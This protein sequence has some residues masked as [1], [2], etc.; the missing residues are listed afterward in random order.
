M[1]QNIDVTVDG[2]LNRFDPLNM[3]S[4][5]EI[6]GELVKRWVPKDRLINRVEVNGENL[7]EQNQERL[8]A[9]RAADIQRIDIQTEPF[10]EAVGGALER[11][12]SYL[13]RVCEGLRLCVDRFRAGQEIEAHK[14]MANS[15]EGL[16]WF[17]GFTTN[18]RV[19]LKLDYDS[20]FFQG[21]SL[22]AKQERLFEYIRELE[23]AQKNMDVVYMA[24]LLEFEIE[25]ILKNWIEILPAFRGRLEAA[26]KS[27]G[28]GAG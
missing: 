22:R 7:T 26:P 23:K 8:S 9:I 3:A 20:E 19:T 25:P 11:G 2:Q 10:S 18:L 21:E 17:V 4:L 5:D 28:N 14:L 24:D 13:D 12:A 16:I 1:S 6:V 27:T 15:M